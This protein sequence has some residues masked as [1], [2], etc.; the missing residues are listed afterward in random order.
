MRAVKHNYLSIGSALRLD[1]EESA[2]IGDGVCVA[3]CV[4]GVVVVVVAACVGVVG[5]FGC[6][7]WYEGGRRAM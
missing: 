4:R 1:H 7:W 3:L 5:V 2:N 6:W